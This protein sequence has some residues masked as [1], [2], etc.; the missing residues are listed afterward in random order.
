MTAPPTNG[1]TT[2][3]PSGSPT[4]YCPSLS[5]KKCRKSPICVR[6]VSGGEE[7]CVAGTYAPTGEFRSEGDGKSRPPSPGRLTQLTPYLLAS[8]L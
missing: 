3:A 6:E 7:T 2:P 4:A 1:P 8:R 5:K